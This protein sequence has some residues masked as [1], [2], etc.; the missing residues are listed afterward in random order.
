MF[1][2]RTLNL[3]AIKAV[4]FDMDYTLVHYQSEEWERRAYEHVKQRLVE[5]GWP[6]G[7]LAFDPAFVRL[8][9]IVDTERGNIVKAN[10]FG[11]VKRAVHGTR[12][13]GFTE[14]RDIYAR[15]PV[16]LSDA[17]W[18]FMNTLFSLSEATLYSQ[19]VDLLDDGQL[20]GAIG[21]EDLYRIVK[22]CLDDTHMEGALKS[23]IV[24][25]PSRFIVR[26]EELPLAL[27]DLKHA[28]KKLL[29]ITNS[30]WSYTRDIMRYCF[31]GLLPKG[32][33]WRDL[34]D[35]VFV[36]ARKPAF[37]E[38]RSPAF[39]VVDEEG[40]LRPVV[41]GIEEHRAYVGGHA[42]LVEDALGVPGEAVLYFGDHVFSDVHVSKSVLRW[43]TGLVVRELEEELVALEQFKERQLTL[44]RLMTEKELKE[45][46]YSQMRLAVQRL[47][48][49]YG[50][51]VGGSPKK[52]KARMQRLRSELVA[53]DEKISPLA[54]ASGQLASSRWGLLMRT[55]N[56]KSHLARQIER[57]AD[58]YT[59]RVSNLLLQTPF[60]FLRSP[61]GSLPHD[62]GPEGGPELE[63]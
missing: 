27:L 15:E 3:R 25:D 9:L 42:G 29:L 34:F 11:Y 57:H 4:G 49:R 13:L 31:E 6:V 5:R 47:E 60:V 7:K 40:L 35:V 54:K 38:T 8:G 36:A 21:Y 58:V 50:P 32:T 17:R 37:F 19:L 2:N 45:H 44:S 52:L 26:D 48:H 23:E 61:R 20:E 63:G 43:R 33:T 16:D 24:S 18:V 46:R 51:R 22:S 1:C 14:V 59:S 39:E 53:L 41:G 12:T 55:G 30:E 28:G 56:D 10:R 62:F